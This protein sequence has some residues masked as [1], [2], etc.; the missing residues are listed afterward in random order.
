MTK[1]LLKEHWGVCQPGGDSLP[2][3]GIEASKEPNSI[4]VK[5]KDKKSTWQGRRGG[6]WMLL[7][8]ERQWTEPGNV[9]GKHEEERKAGDKT[10]ALSC[11]GILSLCLLR[12][13]LGTA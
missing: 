6:S 3:T 11:A 4:A 10:E 7:R 8:E 13:D 2:G 5:E 1:R 12:M 9:V